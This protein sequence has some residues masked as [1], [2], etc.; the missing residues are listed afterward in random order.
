VVPVPPK[1]YGLFFDGDSYI[2]LHVYY[3]L[4]FPSQSSSTNLC[5]N[6]VVQTHGKPE[7]L[8]FDLHFWLGDNTTL[9]RTLQFSVSI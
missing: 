8:R 5:R 2:V 3:Q 1:T 4:L 9:V 6:D 7:S